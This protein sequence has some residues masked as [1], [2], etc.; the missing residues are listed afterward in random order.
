MQTTRIPNIQRVSAEDDI[1][2][3]VLIPCFNEEVAIPKVV[4]DFRNSLPTARIYVYDNNSTDETQR[5]A[6]ESGAIVCSEELQGAGI[7][8]KTAG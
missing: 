8:Q 3:A 2:I 7:D 5:V 1:S 4:T 6:A